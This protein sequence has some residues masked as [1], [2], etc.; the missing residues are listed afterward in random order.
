MGLIFV[1]TGDEVVE[2]EATRFS[3]DEHNNLEIW[4]GPEGDRLVRV[5]TK[6]VWHAVGVDHED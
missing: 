6:G 1:D 5:Y 4:A 3:T 2:M